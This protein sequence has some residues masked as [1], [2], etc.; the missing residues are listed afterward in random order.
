MTHRRDQLAGANAV[1]LVEGS[2]GA[3][4]K[5]ILHGRNDLVEAQALAQVLFWSPTDFAIDDAICGQ[6]EHELF[7]NPR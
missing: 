4:L 3:L 2:I 5:S 6:I 7:G 1:T